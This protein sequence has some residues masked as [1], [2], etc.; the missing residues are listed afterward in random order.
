MLGVH[1]FFH[2]EPCVKDPT[3]AEAILANC[4]PKLGASSVPV[5]SP[6]RAVHMLYAQNT[7]RTLLLAL[8]SPV[9]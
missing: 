3:T 1:N 4:F 8:D 5:V 6:Y 2:H 9:D 7:C